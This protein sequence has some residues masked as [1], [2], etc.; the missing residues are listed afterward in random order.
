[1][2]IGFDEGEQFI[3]TQDLAFGYSAQPPFYNWL[4]YG[5]FCVF[6][7]NQFSMILLKQFILLGIYLAVYATWRKAG[8]TVA[9]AAAC[10]FSMVYI[11]EV[12]WEL[13]RSRTH[14]T[15]AVLMASL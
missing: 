15:A 7:T 6:G 5:F 14:L 1:M 11:T 4:Q 3:V 9:L 12:G 10:T 2:P 13:Q 8:L